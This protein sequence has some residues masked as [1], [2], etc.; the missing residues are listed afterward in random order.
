[1]MQFDLKQDKGGQFYFNVCSDNGTHLVSSH[2]YTTKA[3]AE[4]GIA[5]VENNHNKPERYDIRTQKK[6]LFY[7]ALKASN[8]QVIAISDAC[9]NQNELKETMDILVRG[10]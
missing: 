6:G 10:E 9:K 7:F 4:N 2:L 5:A 8:G 3:A 1:M